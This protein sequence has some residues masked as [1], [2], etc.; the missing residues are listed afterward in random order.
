MG[1]KIELVLP[2]KGPGLRF[3]LPPHLLHFLV[4]ALIEPGGRIPLDAFYERV[5]AHY[6]IA[7]GSR[8]LAVA[9][10]QSEDG[11]MAHHDYA[12]AADTRW[13]EETLRQGDFLVELSDAVSIVRNPAARVDDAEGRV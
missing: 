3:V 10:A 7:L 8:Q 1:K 4:I 13:I 11:G 2:F 6:G 12:V 9:L 5:F